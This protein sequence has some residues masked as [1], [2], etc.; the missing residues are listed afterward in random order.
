M[1]AI[2]DLP[3]VDGGELG[4]DPAPSCARRPAGVLVEPFER[5][6]DVRVIAEPVVAVVRFAV[7]GLVEAGELGEAVLLRV[8]CLVERGVEDLLG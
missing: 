5:R 7:A 8:R 4:R 3:Q 2:L 1:P 6:A